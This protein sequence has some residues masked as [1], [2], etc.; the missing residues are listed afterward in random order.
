MQTEQLQLKV[1]WICLGST[2]PYTFKKKLTFKY[3]VLYI[4]LSFPKI[5]RLIPYTFMY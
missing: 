2:L 3:D 5:K 1:N 4:N